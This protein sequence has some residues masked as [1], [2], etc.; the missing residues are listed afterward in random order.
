MDWTLLIAA[1]GAATG[2]IALAVA[3]LTYVRDR[4]RLVVSCSN[5]VVFD[6]TRSSGPLVIIEAVNAGRRPIRLESAGFIA[7]KSPRERLV[8]F[9]DLHT[10]PKTLNESEKVSVQVKLDSV[11][12][13]SIGAGKG[14][15]TIAYFLDSTGRLHK[16]KVPDAVRARVAA[17]TSTDRG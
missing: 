8:T 11:Y 17:T 5:G 10:F 9:G 6:A 7:E 16:C 4:A 12:A 15:P 14:N 2:S 13:E 3:V 1:W